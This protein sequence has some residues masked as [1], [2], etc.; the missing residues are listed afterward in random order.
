METLEN[1]HLSFRYSTTALFITSKAA[2]HSR[3][4]SRVVST[5]NAAM[6]NSSEAWSCGL[7]ASLR[8]RLLKPKRSLPQTETNTSHIRWS[9]SK[10]E[11]AWEAAK[12][13]LSP[14]EAV[15][16][17]NATTLSSLCATKPRWTHII[18]S[19]PSHNSSLL[20]KCHQ[21]AFMSCP[22]GSC[23]QFSLPSKCLPGSMR[24]Q[25]P[26]TVGKRETMVSISKLSD[27]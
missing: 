21:Y 14:N 18:L 10:R 5:G 13:H 22:P 27:N 9:T 7:F 16:T 2:D 26:L 8:E 15:N 23:K 6:N 4:P 25:F 12:T 11:W 20:R 19:Q 3:S 24:T 17:E 1:S